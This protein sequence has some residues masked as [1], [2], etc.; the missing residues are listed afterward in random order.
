MDLGTVVKISTYGDVC[1]K[2]WV[3]CAT[4]V[5]AFFFEDNFDRHRN[6][7]AKPAIFFAF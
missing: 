1:P 6:D 7:D 5:K 4:H 3:V 2:D